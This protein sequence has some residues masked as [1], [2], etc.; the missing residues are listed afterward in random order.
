M[1]ED[2]PD[3]DDKVDFDS[4]LQKSLELIESKE[5]PM[6]GL[7]VKM[8]IANLR[9]VSMFISVELK[10]KSFEILVK[11][12]KDPESFVYLAAVHALAHLVSREKPLFLH[13]LVAI[14]TETSQPMTMRERVLLVEVLV[15][16]T[17][18]TGPSAANFCTLLVNACIKLIRFRPGVH[19]EKLLTENSIDLLSH[20]SASTEPDT[21][22]S[23]SIEEGF[24]TAD[25][26][27]LRQSA[28]S[29]L[30]EITV[31]AG[32]TSF[33]FLFEIIDVA[34][35]IIRVESYHSQVT[36]YAR[37]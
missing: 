35:G 9:D 5:P 29:L 18:R 32:F 12:L 13:S 8:L 16:V 21:T 10:E 34:L 20:R 7:G 1:V 11:L 4:V 24:Y 30:A 37:R 2:Q 15:L 31:A 3:C 19:E 26:V 23:E 6:R 33:P 27:I 36:I 14:L 28:V 17:R 22:S 25:S